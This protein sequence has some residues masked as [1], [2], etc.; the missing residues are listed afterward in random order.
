MTDKK[1]EFVSRMSLEQINAELAE[2]TKSPSAI[3]DIVKAQISLTAARDQ[4][5]GNSKGNKPIVSAASLKEPLKAATLPSMKDKPKAKVVK[6]TKAKL[7]TK[8]APVK[9]VVKPKAK[10][11]VVKKAVVKANTKAMKQVKKLAQKALSKVGYST[12]QRAKASKKSW[13]I[14]KVAKARS[15]RCHVKVAGH[16]EFVSVKASFDQLNIPIK[17]RGAL[18]LEI[19]KNGKA[20]LVH[21]K[22]TFQYTHIKEMSA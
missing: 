18:R 12:A 4:I 7:A 21:G 17:Y 6:I 16:G 11:K 13:A 22:K 1:L 19:K 9:A 2:L 3:D 14:P 8:K 15:T 20:K 5:L 10:V